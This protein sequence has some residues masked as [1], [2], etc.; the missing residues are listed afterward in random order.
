LMLIAIP[1]EIK[2]LPIHIVYLWLRADAQLREFTDNLSEEDKHFIQNSSTEVVWI[3]YDLDP[4]SH[5][6]ESYDSAIDVGKYCIY[7][8]Y[9][10]R[11]ERQAILDEEGESITETHSQ[12]H[13]VLFAQSS[14]LEENQDGMPIKME[15]IE[16]APA[17]RSID[18]A[19]CH[20][21]VSL[22]AEKILNKLQEHQRQCIE[23]LVQARMVDRECHNDVKGCTGQGNGHNCEN[24]GLIDDNSER[25]LD[26]SW[27]ECIHCKNG[28]GI[29]DHEC[30]L[31]Q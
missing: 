8:C 22:H 23:R 19:P 15:A 4:L 9:D 29:L 31:F 21:E 26:S 18:I 27:I 25:S 13:D 3:N 1:F 6:N 5:E 12:P 16:A 30:T 20:F 14:I 10:E 2:Y 28:S 24:A 17:S 7:E 11:C